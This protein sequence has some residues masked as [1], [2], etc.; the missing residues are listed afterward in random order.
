MYALYQHFM[1]SRYI[2]LQYYL[3]IYCSINTIETRL[4]LRTL[5]FSS[6][7][8]SGRASASSFLSKG[9]SSKYGMPASFKVFR[10]L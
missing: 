2:K 4:S 3:D 7:L 1:K 10:F 6:I 9:L 5:Y 8:Q